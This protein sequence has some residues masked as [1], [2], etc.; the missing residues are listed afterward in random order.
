[1][2][3]GQIVLRQIGPCLDEPFGIERDAPMEPL[4]AGNGTGHEKDVPYVVGLDA[5]GLMVAPAD[6]FEMMIPFE[7]HDFG[8]GAEDDGR[9]L[10]DAANQIA[11]HAL[12]QPIRSHEHMHA[13]AR[14]REKDGRLAGGVAPSDHNDLFTAA[15]LCFHK[16]R[17]VVH[18]RRPRTATSSRG[19][20][21]DRRRPLR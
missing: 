18:T 12:R 16:C 19:T 1:M 3:G 17:A 20:V 8:V 7:G 13:L 15:Q 6:S 21:S 14:L 5:S 9:I 2:R 4:C 11:R 10:F